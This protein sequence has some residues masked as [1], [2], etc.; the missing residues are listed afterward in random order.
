MPEL[1]SRCNLPDIAP[2]ILNCSPSITVGQVGHSFNFASTGFHRLATGSIYI[3]YV[4]VQACRKCWAF[5]CITDH[6]D[7]VANPHFGWTLFLKFT[8]CLEHAAN[9]FNQ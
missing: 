5:G 6:D 7:R 9:E 4:Y 3:R 8:R 2:Q 1:L